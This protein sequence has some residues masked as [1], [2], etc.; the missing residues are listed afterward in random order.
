MLILTLA[1]VRSLTPA[2]L[3]SNILQVEAAERLKR[4]QQTPLPKIPQIAAGG[5]FDQIDGEFQQAHFP[6]VI[7]TLDHRAERFIRVLDAMSGAID[8]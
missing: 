6:C 2:R 7:D 1:A 4:L 3:S 5:T 8:H